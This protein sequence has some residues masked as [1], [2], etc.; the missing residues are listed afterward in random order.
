M[1]NQKIFLFLTKNSSEKQMS[2][3]Y[4]LVVSYDLKERETI[5]RKT[6]MIKLVIYSDT[7][8]TLI[9]DLQQ[10]KTNFVTL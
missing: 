8:H 7:K 2:P 5:K 6:K 9:R 3:G 4:T 1:G 10:Q